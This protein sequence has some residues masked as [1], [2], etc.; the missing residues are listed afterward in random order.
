MTIG[1]RSLYKLLL[2]LFV[3][4]AACSVS[5]A[6]ATGS[7]VGTVSDNAGAVLPG[8]RVTLT[9]LAT[10]ETQVVQS[11]N[12][13]N[14][15]FLQ[16]M[17]GNYK[18][19]A[20]HAG[21]QLF[22]VPSA[23]VVVGNAT[24]VDAIMQI[25]RQTQTVEVAAQAALLST[26]SS[27]LD[28]N[29]QSS[30]V[31]QLPLNGRN[32]INL[33]ELVPGVVPQGDT[34][35]NAGNN[36]MS[37]GAMN[38]FGNYQIG[39]GSANQSAIFIDGAPV[40]GSMSNSAMLVPNQDSTQEF[41]VA[42]NNVSPEYGRFAGGV[43][44][45]STKSGTNDFHGALYEYVRNAALNANSWWGNH[46][47]LSRPIYTQ[48]QFGAAIGGPVVKNKVFFFANWEDFDLA[49]A[50][51]IQTNVPTAAMLA[52]DFSA[53]P[54]QLYDP[55][56]QT[57]AVG[58]NG[59]GGSSRC[60]YTLANGYGGTDPGQSPGAPNQIPAGELNQTALNIDKILFPPPTPNNSNNVADGDPN[61]IM[62]TPVRTVT[63][64][65]VG[66]GDEILGRNKLF[67]RYTNWHFNGSVAPMLP[68]SANYGVYNEFGVDQAV[69]GDTVTIGSTMIADVRASF[70]R[71]FYPYF[72]TSCCNF[73]VA[74]KIGPG[75]SGIQA[76]ETYPQAPTPN[77]TG[78][79]NFF[80]LDTATDTDESYALSGDFTNIVGGDSITFGAELRR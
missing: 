2:C 13:G 22:A 49:Q 41:Q 40:N 6:Q 7:L 5:W 51:L 23:Q 20:D 34:T 38:M 21:F 48:N 28:Y 37:A 74:S 46:D 61:F 71:F 42:T 68:G 33:A 56:N 72:P 43:I 32:P 14:F 70:I 76:A 3:G 8:T 62:N 55:N 80:W 60:A 45:M 12:N 15:R 58:G 78:M 66:R 75:W 53:M 54:T 59:P 4:L 65:Y 29:V 52:G 25:G 9:N 79:N 31:E 67:E 47:G 35:G 36:F 50:T 1:R 44:N 77:I 27:S 26:Q 10:N 73:D 16:L 64:Q 69:V 57:C 11:D 24:R 17:P 18:V 63:N 19:V 39:G 30:Q